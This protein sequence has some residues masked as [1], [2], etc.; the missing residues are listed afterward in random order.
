ER[1]PLDQEPADWPVH[2]DG[3]GTVPGS[4]PTWDRFWGGET[5]CHPGPRCRSTGNVA[6]WA[7]PGPQ[8]QAL[9]EPCRTPPHPEGTPRRETAAPRPPRPRVARP[10]LRLRLVAPR[11]RLRPGGPR[12]LLHREGP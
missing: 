11:L 3:R 10:R 12:P 7:D 5:T 9:E 2:H 8:R 4:W 1:S 6:R